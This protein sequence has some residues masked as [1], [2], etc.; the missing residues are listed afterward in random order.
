M[1]KLLLS[2]C[3]CSLLSAETILVPLD[4]KF[5]KTEDAKFYC[6]DNIVVALVG[7]TEMKVVWNNPYKKNIVEVLKCK[8]FNTWENL[9]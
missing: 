8:D 6:V 1:K 9:N 4:E 3:M 7:N 2:I 5:S